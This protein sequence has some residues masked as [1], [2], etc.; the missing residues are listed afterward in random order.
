MVTQK[1]QCKGQ[2]GQQ[3]TPEGENWA[4]HMMWGNEEVTER[5]CI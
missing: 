1:R 4:A 3:Q 5:V 2:L